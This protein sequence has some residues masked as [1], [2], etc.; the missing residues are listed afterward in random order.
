MRTAYARSFI[1]DLKKLEG[2][3]A[4]S[5]IHTLAFETVPQARTLGEVANLKKLTGY[6]DAY[7]IKLGEYRLGLTLEGE[8]VVFRRVLHRKDIYRYFP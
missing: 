7:R 6:R 3:D 5:R 1:K 4:Y 2:T 8:T